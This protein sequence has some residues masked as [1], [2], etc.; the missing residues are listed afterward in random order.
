M[1]DSEK[2]V[3]TMNEVQGI[4]EKQSQKVS[5]TDTQVGEVLQEVEQAIKAIS[6]VASKTEKINAT[7][8]NVVDTVQNLSAIAE[9]NAASTEET[10][11]AAVE[12]SNIITD[13]ADNAKSLKEISQLIEES[14]SIFEI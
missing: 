11:A 10:S 8:G 9:E 5:N 14:M 3:N 12:V 7:R 1:E 13:I 6:N 2:A 4:M